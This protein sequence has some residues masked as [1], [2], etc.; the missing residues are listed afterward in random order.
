MT[1]RT[2]CCLPVGYRD[3][4]EFEQRM[5]GVTL[6]DHR[7]DART[8]QAVRGRFES[9]MT[10]DGANFVRPMRPGTQPGADGSPP[11]AKRWQCCRPLR[12][13]RRHITQ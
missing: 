5:V 11:R 1:K 12:N 7:L 13:R 8:F 3:F 2:A 6:L 4:A 10:A 9:H